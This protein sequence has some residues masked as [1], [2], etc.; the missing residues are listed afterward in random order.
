MFPL[1]FI[2][3]A[4][5]TSFAIFGVGLLHVG[6]LFRRVEPDRWR[7]MSAHRA[8]NAVVVLTAA[9]GPTALL[10]L[11]PNPIGMRTAIWGIVIPP[12]IGV[13]IMGTFFGR[14]NHAKSKGGPVD[15]ELWGDRWS[16]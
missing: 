6:W 4:V 7:E 9:I 3:L 1:L 11:S 10:C 8:R 5:A 16:E 13:V 12:L 15:P 14:L 2:V